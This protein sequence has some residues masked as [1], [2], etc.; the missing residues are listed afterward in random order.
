VQKREDSRTETERHNGLI[1]MHPLLAGLHG[2]PDF[3]RRPLDVR[4][5]RVVFWAIGALGTGVVGEKAKIGVKVYIG[6][7]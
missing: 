3:S 6:R 7:E 5:A 4:Q 2:P 1:E